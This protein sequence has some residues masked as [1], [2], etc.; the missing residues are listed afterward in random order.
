MCIS[1]VNFACADVFFSDFSF[2]MSSQ[3]F[4]LHIANDKQTQQILSAL[5][6]KQRLICISVSLLSSVGYISEEDSSPSCSL[7][8]DSMKIFGIEPD[9]GEL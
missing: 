2:L 8:S 7:Q 4:L 6:S 9:L 5:L 3:P 1:T